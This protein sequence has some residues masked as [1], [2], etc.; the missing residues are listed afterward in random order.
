LIRAGCVFGLLLA[1]VAATEQAVAQDCS[2][3]PAPPQIEVSADVRAAVLDTSTSLRNL[4]ADAGP[5]MGPNSHTLGTTSLNVMNNL[6][7]QSRGMPQAGGGFCWSVTQV[8]AIVRADTTVNIASEITRDS[9]MWREVMAHEKK[10]VALDRQLLPNLVAATRARLMQLGNQS[11]SA[12]SEAVASAAFQAAAERALNEAAD[13]YFD[14]RNAQQLALDT[15]EEY[16]R[17][18]RACGDAEVAEVLGR[19]GIQ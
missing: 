1:I 7:L 3:V 4:S 18:S 12:A 11:I 13:Q 15:P 14:G 9:C 5:A 8:K 16:A 19:A 6:Q 2:G 17:L 10:H